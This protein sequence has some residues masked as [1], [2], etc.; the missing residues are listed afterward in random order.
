MQ[1]F[2][3]TAPGRAHVTDVPMPDAVPG[4]TVLEVGAC[5]VCGTDLHIYKGE[6]IGSYPIVPGH[7]IAGTVVAIG[8]GVTRVGVG[9]RVAIEPNIACGVCDECLSNRENFC[10]N[11][12]A[13]GVTLPGGMAEHVA[14]PEAALFPVRDMPF[15]RAAFVEPLSCVLHGIESVGI[16]SGDRVAVFGAG[17]I[18]M[19]LAWCARISGA[20]Y[21]DVLER[22][23][24]RRERAAAAADEVFASASDLPKDRYDVVIEA[25]GAPA[26][27]PTAIEAVR[28]GGRILL[29]GVPSADAT[30]TV[31]PFMLF[32][33]GIT[34]V[35]TYTSRRNSIQAV[36][37]LE[38]GAVRPETLITHTVGLGGIVDAFDAV[39]S[40]HDDVLKAVVLPGSR[41]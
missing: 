16:E 37:L 41:V 9:D 25:A 22:G 35:A 10:E 21:I 2:Q 26:L 38:S 13:V 32:R 40:A 34:I 36:R 17:P 1:V 15:E 18:G 5:G 7:E 24:F 4:W 12:Q 29:F 33:K 23:T 27:I 30:A 31:T 39:E 6:Y 19:L 28:P 8:S 20:G 11:W 14:V 3:I